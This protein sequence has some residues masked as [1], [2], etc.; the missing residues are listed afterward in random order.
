MFG[1]IFWSGCYKFDIQC[2]I[3][4]ICVFYIGLKMMRDFLKCDIRKGVDG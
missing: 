1:V 3:I 2:K 4:F